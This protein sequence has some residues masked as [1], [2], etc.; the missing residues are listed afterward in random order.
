M[1]AE[2]N[3]SEWRSELYELL[4]RYGFSDHEAS[5]VV[6]FAEDVRDARGG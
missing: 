2:E 6:D 1:S 5:A 4:V 3:N